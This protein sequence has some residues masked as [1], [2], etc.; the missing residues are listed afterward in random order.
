M[1]LNQWMCLTLAEEHRQYRGNAGYADVPARGYAYDSTVP[2]HMDVCV[3]DVL[4]LSNGLRLIWAGRVGVIRAWEDTKDRQRC[5]SCHTT[6]LRAR[7]GKTPVFRCNKCRSEFDVPILETIPVTSR[8]AEFAVPWQVSG[9][10]IVHRHLAD[11]CKSPRNQHAIRTLQAT[12]L[13]ALLDRGAVFSRSA[14]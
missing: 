7:K 11:L 8:F 9:K 6:D 5:P 3:G 1:D 2:H 12:T 10:P 14:W 4:F 13:I